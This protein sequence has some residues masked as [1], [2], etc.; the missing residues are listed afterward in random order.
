MVWNLIPLEI[1]NLS[2]FAFK[3]RLKDTTY[4]CI[5]K[6]RKIF[7]TLFPKTFNHFALSIA[8][9]QSFGWLLDSITDKVY[10]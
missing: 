1:Q 2:K 7:V 6:L 10:L 4:S 9:L 8:S 3:K 5:H